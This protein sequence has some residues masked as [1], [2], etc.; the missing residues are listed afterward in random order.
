VSKIRVCVCECAHAPVLKEPW[1]RVFETD[2][3]FQTFLFVCPLQPFLHLPHSPNRALLFIT[4]AA[5]LLCYVQ[6]TLVFS[7]YGST[8]VAIQKM[9]EASQ[10][11]MTIGSSNEEIE[12]SASIGMTPSTEALRVTN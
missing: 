12:G 7:I 9:I 6:I 2:E 8:E 10:R 4:I 1:Q 3:G 11:M 5:L